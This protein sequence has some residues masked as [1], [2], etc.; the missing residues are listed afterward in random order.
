MTGGSANGAAA[1]DS[2]FT[3]KTDPLL[4]NYRVNFGM[5]GRGTLTGTAPSV[6]GGAAA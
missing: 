3:K 6:A 4:P 2:A 5:S 1:L